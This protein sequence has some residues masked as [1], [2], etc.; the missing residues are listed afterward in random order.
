MSN[1]SFTNIKAFL[2]SWGLHY[3][4]PDGES[5]EIPYPQVYTRMQLDAGNMGGSELQ[6][7]ISHITDTTDGKTYL[8]PGDWDEI[9]DVMDVWFGRDK[10]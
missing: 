2:E 1:L 7:F 4:T 10:L 6:Q 8:V 3:D 5:N 9:M